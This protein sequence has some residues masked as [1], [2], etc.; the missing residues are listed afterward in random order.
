MSKK[1][2]YRKEIK[3]RINSKKKIV[4]LRTAFG[5]NNQTHQASY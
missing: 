4:D 1:G 2:I 5:N 3:T